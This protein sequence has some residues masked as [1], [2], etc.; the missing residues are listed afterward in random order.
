MDYYI[1]LNREIALQIFGSEENIPDNVLIDNY[2]ELDYA[3][4]N[5]YFEEE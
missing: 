1:I 4:I 3:L 2:L 5:N